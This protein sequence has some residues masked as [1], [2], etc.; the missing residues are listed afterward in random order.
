M[1]GS[2]TRWKGCPGADRHARPIPIIEDRLSAAGPFIFRGGSDAKRGGG[3]ADLNELKLS[4][5]RRKGRIAKASMPIARQQ[6][7]EHVGRLLQTHVFASD[8]QCARMNRQG[9]VA[10][11]LEQPAHNRWVAGPNPAGP[12]APTITSK[13][14]SGDS[15][16]G[17]PWLNEI[18]PGC[19]P[20]RDFDSRLWSCAR[21]GAGCR[22]S[23]IS[24][25]WN[26]ACAAPG[27]GL[28]WGEGCW[29]HR[30]LHC[31]HGG[32]RREWESDG[33]GKAAGRK[34]TN[35]LEEGEPPDVGDHPAALSRGRSAVRARGTGAAGAFPLGAPGCRYESDAGPSKVILPQIW[36]R[37]VNI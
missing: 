13:P 20:P 17:L 30:L 5:R 21:G 3:R 32:L 34:R 24:A 10:Q 7:A 2:E 8:S 15:S 35:C 12:I 23:R 19:T 36:S 22:H 27:E 16:C 18:A 14:L 11:W 31:L 37:S 28:Q 1:S 9:P 33:G 25:G 26:R 6:P 29:G 4:Q